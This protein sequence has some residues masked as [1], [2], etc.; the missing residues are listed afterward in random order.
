[1]LKSKQ[2]SKPTWFHF[3]STPTQSDK[4]YHYYNAIICLNHLQLK[5]EIL[6]FGN[7]NFWLRAQQAVI[8]EVCPIKFELR[9]G[10]TI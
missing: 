1:M 7:T 10:V 6:D 9:Q 8:Q 3:F 5:V 2:T 4:E